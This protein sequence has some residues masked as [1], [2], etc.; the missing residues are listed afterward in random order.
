[1]SK[2]NLKITNLLNEGFFDLF[3]K[4]GFGVLVYDFIYNSETKSEKTKEFLSYQEDDDYNLLEETVYLD[5]NK[6]PELNLIEYIKSNFIENKEILNLEILFINAYGDRK[7]LRINVQY[8]LKDF[9]QDDDEDD[10]Q[11]V[12]TKKLSKRKLKELNEEKENFKNDINNLEK[13]ILLIQD[14][15][16]EKK[17]IQHSKLFDIQFRGTFQNANIGMAIVS[18]EGKILEA[19]NSFCAFL[20]INNIEIKNTTFQELTHPEDL[21][22][23]IKQFRRCLDGEISSYTIEKRYFNKIGNTIWGRLTATLIRDNDNEPI[24][25]ISHIEDITEL[26][27]NDQ[28]ITETNSQIMTILNADTKVGIFTTNHNGQFKQVSKGTYN[29]LGYDVDDLSLNENSLFFIIKMMKSDKHYNLKN[30]EQNLIDLDPKMK[31]EEF[32]KGVSAEKEE[33]RICLCRC[34]NQKEIY[35]DLVINAITNDNDEITGYVFF[36]LDISPLV[37]NV[38]D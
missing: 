17:I 15:S 26:K 21:L 7:F 5:K 18:L 19:N 3:E 1:M 34:K 13:V 25:F 36:I 2:S 29:L 6:L 22:I 10:N 16:N 11:V 27:V 23:D 8:V 33:Q 4:S 12:E 37:I 35:C 24:H 38:K 9:D 20:G 31:F 28:I 30:I 32:V 14:Y